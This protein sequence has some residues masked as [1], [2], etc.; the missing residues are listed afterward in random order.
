MVQPP[1]VAGAFFVRR[2]IGRGRRCGVPG[3]D[4]VVGPAVCIPAA[5]G[6]LQIVPDG[7]EKTGAAAVRFARIG[8]QRSDQEFWRI[9]KACTARLGTREAS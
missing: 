1:P 5:V 9:W 7:L 8:A 6:D 3:V 2:R 4:A